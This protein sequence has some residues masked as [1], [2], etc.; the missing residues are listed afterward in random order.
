M[1]DTVHVDKAIARRI[2]AGDQ[3]AFKDVFDR[4]FPRLYRYAVVRLDGD[5]EAARDV[6]QQTF[7]KAI[8]RLDTYRGEAA[9]YAWF[10]RICR[11]SLIDYCRSRNRELQRV[12]PLEDRSEVRA[13]LDAIAGPESDQPEVQAGRRDTKR[14]VQ[15]TLDRLPAR[16]GDILEWKY[17]QG[18]SVKEIAGRL[19]L[20]P[21]AAESLLTRARVAFRNA[22]AA[23]G[24]T[25]DVRIGE[26]PVGR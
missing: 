25:A 8:E 15:A 18:L 22:I 20:K 16:Y 11:N 4:Y 21:K 13:I 3:Q 12:V 9:L 10:T 24:S 6:V 23:L 7:C 2:L 5:R 26:G 1:S 14:L 17:V 19:A